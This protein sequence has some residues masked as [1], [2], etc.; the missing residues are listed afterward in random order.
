MI[1]D[2]VSA[3]A[4]RRTSERATDER[5][6]GNRT[7]VRGLTE[8]N[9]VSRVPR[10][11]DARVSSGDARGASA[12]PRAA[13]GSGGVEEH[14]SK[15]SPSAT[16]LQPGEVVDPRV[17][18][19]FVDEL[20]EIGLHVTPREDLPEQEPRRERRLERVHVLRH[21]DVVPE[22]SP[23]ELRH[24]ARRGE[25]RSPPARA[26]LR[27]RNPNHSR[28]TQNRNGPR[29]V[30]RRHDA[31]VVRDRPVAVESLRDASARAIRLRAVTRTTRDGPHAGLTG[32]E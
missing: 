10:D 12:R 7:M 18:R 4:S 20:G 13:R 15:K 25:T 9:D 23:Q 32:C 28:R 22:P 31:G 6:R 19:V 26:S 14:A 27:G 16:Y 21:P 29:V 17:R 30:D 8:P 1:R 3:C 24:R 2:G 5:N 11:W